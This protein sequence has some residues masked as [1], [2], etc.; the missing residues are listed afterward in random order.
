[1]STEARSSTRKRGGGATSRKTATR[2]SVPR[3]GRKPR[4]EASQPAAGEL[5]G[6]APA[7]APHD[8]PWGYDRTRITAIARDPS[9]LYVGWEVTDSALAAAR[10][11]LGAGGAE[12]SCALR[13]YD[14]TFR[15]FDGHNANSSFDVPVDRAW[16]HYFL[17][18]DRPR[19]TF[20]VDLGLK[21]A[22]GAF[23][24]LARSGAA[25]M[26]PDG[27]AADGPREWMTVTPHQAAPKTRPYRHRFKPAPMVAQAGGSWGGGGPSGGAWAPSQTSSVDFNQVLASLVGGHV[28]QGEWYEQVM[29]GRVVRWVRWTG[30][31]KITSWRTSTASGLVESLGPVEV[32]FEGQRRVLTAGGATRSELGPWHL[33]IAGLDAQRQRRVFD[34]W[35]IHMMWETGATF[36]RAQTPALYRRILGGY[37]HRQQLGDGSEQLVHEEVGSSE[38]LMGG[39]S[40][41]V[42]AGASELL[43]AGG[44]EVMAL[45]ASEVFGFGA[46][47]LAWLGASETLLGG[48]SLYRLGGASGQE[49]GGASEQLLGGASP[50]GVAWGS[51]LGGASELSFVGGSELVVGLSSGQGWGGFSVLPATDGPLEGRGSSVSAAAVL[52]APTRLPGSPAA[53]APTGRTKAKSSSTTRRRTKR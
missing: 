1:M 15:L 29:G 20:H 38:E 49:W 33:V 6:D 4:D 44:S 7:P 13:V 2:T 26:P 3:T 39:A 48:A 28:V 30:T 27:I 11:Q 46:S 18:L 32:W 19:A 23:A 40:E 14:T 42:F 43:M 17:R 8:L 52:P 12:A 10:A 37:R 35:L 25:E 53:A 51:A 21:S 31:R 9:F 36:E 45:G 24:L 16:N 41:R 50:G 5:R 22:D 34:T 47:E